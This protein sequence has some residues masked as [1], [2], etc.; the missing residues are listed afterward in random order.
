MINI[1]NLPDARNLLDG[2]EG[3]EG[4]GKDKLYDIYYQI[5]TAILKYRLK[6]N[7]SQTKLAKKL[8]VTQA[9]VSKLE[10]GDYNYTIEQLWKVSQKLGF[11]LNIAFEEEDE[12]I[13]L[14]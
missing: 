8:G 1:N 11:K 7:L 13:S 10:S 9:M 12:K 2:L 14:V 3:E 6:H 5:S 4:N